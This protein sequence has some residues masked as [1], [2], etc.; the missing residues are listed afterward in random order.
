MEFMTNPKVP[1]TWDVISY[2]EE[3]AAE[4]KAKEEAAAAKAGMAQA[5]VKVAAFATPV[6]SGG[7]S[8]VAPAV[9]R[10]KKFGSRSKKLPPGKPKRQYKWKDES[11]KNKGWKIDAK[12]KVE[13]E[14]DADEGDDEDDEDDY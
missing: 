3:L 12:A 2:R 4:K 6:T 14:D 8:M 11:R 10:P 5:K 7:N 1:K 13:D 9:K